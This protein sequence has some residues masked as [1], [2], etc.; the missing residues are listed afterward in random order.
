M[1]KSISKMDVKISVEFIPKEKYFV[2]TV[3]DQPMRIFLNKKDAF[4]FKCDYID[5]FDEDGLSVKTYKWTGKEFTKN[6]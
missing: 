3:G 1:Q 6:F 2:C 5:S 4:L